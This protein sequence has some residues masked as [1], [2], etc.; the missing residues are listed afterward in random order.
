MNGLAA[1]AR[2]TQFS[3]RF[4]VHSSTLRAT[5]A[6]DMN[7]WIPAAVAAAMLG[8]IAT[9]L[10]V[11][12]PRPHGAAPAVSASVGTAST[13]ALPAASEQVLPPLPLGS[14][15]PPVAPHGF[16]KL[17]NGEPVPALPKTA[18]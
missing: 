16:D 14:A 9:Y 1:L 2:C 13:A 4:R 5:R 11:G 6:A 10:V 15:T 8:G 7:R 12:R 18:P 17:P 3:C